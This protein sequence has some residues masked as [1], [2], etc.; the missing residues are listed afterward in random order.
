MTNN[1]CFFLEII[2]LCVNMLCW[3]L[4]IINARNGS[5]NLTYTLMIFCVCV[6]A[7]V[8]EYTREY[9]TGLS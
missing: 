5:S 6:C 4:Y 3:V 8:N 9:G 7:C 2:Y 1:F